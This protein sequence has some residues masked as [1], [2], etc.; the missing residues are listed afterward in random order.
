MKRYQP[1]VPRTF[2]AMAA[3]ALSATTLALLVAVPSKMEP[4]STM[5]IELARA[6][7]KL[8]CQRPPDPECLGAPADGNASAPAQG[9][10]TGLNCG[11]SG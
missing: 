10:G 2:L 7:L 8:Q 3:V 5:Y 1:P 4:D 9:R 11:P 6:D